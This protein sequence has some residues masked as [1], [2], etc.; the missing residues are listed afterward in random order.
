[1]LH[2]RRARANSTWSSSRRSA[3]LTAATRRSRAPLTC[4]MPA[5]GRP[6]HCDELGR[7]VTT[8]IQC[9]MP[10]PHLL[11]RPMRRADTRQATATGQTSPRLRHALPR[12]SR[13]YPKHYDMPP[14][15][16]HYPN[17]L[18][19]CALTQTESLRHTLPRR[20]FPMRHAANMQMPPNA[21][22]RPD[23]PFGHYTAT[24][25][26]LP[27]T[28][29]PR[30]TPLRQAASPPLRQA[31]PSL[32]RTVP[33]HC[34]MPCRIVSCS[35]TATCLAVIEPRRCG[36]PSS[37]RLRRCDKPR[38]PQPR[39]A[40]Q[41]M[42]PLATLR[43]ASPSAPG[44]RALVIRQ[45]TAVIRKLGWPAFAGFLVITHAGCSSTSTSLAE[46]SG[47]AAGSHPDAAGAQGGGGGQAGTGGAPAGGQA[48][49]PDAGPDAK[50]ADSGPDTGGPDASPDAGTPDA[51]P[52][53]PPPTGCEQ[54]KCA[55]QLN[56]W[57][58]PTYPIASNMYCTVAQ[59]ICC[60]CPA[61]CY[62]R[63][64][65]KGSKNNPIGGA[66]WWCCE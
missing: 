32:C 65:C 19:R 5:P 23:F 41:I 45:R 28:P 12:T 42:T 51:G 4:D 3:E 48:G 29:S 61:S 43:V 20:D 44:A 13:I 16:R 57:C 63:V 26:V 31:H 53:A 1:V 47:G 15:R 2:A 25:Q 9:D 60:F 54:C 35:A 40:L 17:S 55:G 18:R 38:Q 30:D 59:P 14:S 66:T 52:D 58:G 62:E 11:L 22:C 36:M 56:Q 10:H 24:C 8:P 6:D 7:H 33:S 50:P 39:K 49:A 46:A 27:P 37:A 34:D 64:G 21:T